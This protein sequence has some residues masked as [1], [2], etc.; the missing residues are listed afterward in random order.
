M[1]IDGIVGTLNV[2]GNSHTLV[3]Y[4]QG[5]RSARDKAPK[6]K[7]S[8]ASL[9]KALLAVT[10]RA[11]GLQDITYAVLHKALHDLA[12]D[13]QEG[14]RSVALCCIQVG[15]RFGTGRTRAVFHKAGWTLNCSIHW[16]SSVKQG[17]STTLKA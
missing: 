15:P 10:Q 8:G 7:L 9:T 4:L 1:V 13:I 5:Q 2:Q 11:A 12:Q 17:T 6:C 16:N 3:L 14:N